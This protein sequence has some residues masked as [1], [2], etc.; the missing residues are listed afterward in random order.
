MERIGGFL[1][2][3][4]IGALTFIF[5]Y[6][7]LQVHKPA[8]E[9]IPAPDDIIPTD[10]EVYDLRTYLRN[11]LQIESSE[12]TCSIPN[13][14]THG[15]FEGIYDAKIDI[16]GYTDIPK[17]FPETSYVP[18]D[19][20]IYAIALSKP[21]EYEVPQHPGTMADA[22]SN[23]V[24]I[25]LIRDDIDRGVS[26]IN[27]YGA[28][29]PFYVLNTVTNDVFRSSIYALSEAKT[30][31]DAVNDSVFRISGTD[32]VTYGIVEAPTNIRVN[33]KAQ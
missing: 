5:V 17:D 19:V 7:L 14:N 8:P 26:I 13:Y 28:G 33:P 23:Y 3:F 12:L 22:P 15:G 24:P 11:N 20:G 6:T 18:K 9:V 16:V 32:A 2:S 27:N 25:L 10:A 29:Y 31:D 4:G 21:V 1:V 30:L